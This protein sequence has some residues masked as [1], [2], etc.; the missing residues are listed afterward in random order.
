MSKNLPL[1]CLFTMNIYFCFYVNTARDVVTVF[2]IFVNICHFTYTFSHAH[3]E[4]HT[5]KHTCMISTQEEWQQPGTGAWL[6]AVEERLLLET[7]AWPNMLCKAFVSNNSLSSTAPNQAPV[8]GC[9]HS[10][11]VLIIH[12]CLCVCASVCARENVQI[13]WS[14]LTNIRKTV[15]M[16]RAVQPHLTHTANALENWRMHADA[17]HFRYQ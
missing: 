15:T 16:S 14:I 4:A 12:V 6:G 17:P 5:H 7:K 8:P 13:E 2:L 11:C 10:S 3:T 9:C 1:H